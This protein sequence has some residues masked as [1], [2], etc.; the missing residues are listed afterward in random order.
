ML[1]KI[2]GT[3][4]AIGR[5]ISPVWNFIK[6]FFTRLCVFAKKHK[7]LSVIIAVLL[8]AA[9][10]FSLLPG[11][12]GKGEM[13]DTSEVTVSRMTISQTISGSSVVEANDEYSVTPLAYGEIL[14]ADF[15]EGDIVEKGQVLYEIDSSDA[16]S[17]IKSSDLS[18]ERAQNS[19]AD[20]ADAM[21]D[22][23]V[24]AEFSGTVTEVYVSEGDE[25]SNGAKIA[26]IVN[27]STMKVRVP[28]NTADAQ[29]IR[30]G[31]AATV[32]LVNTGKV[33]SGSITSVSSGSETLNGSMR[34]SYVT[35]KVSN[36]GA[37]MAGDSVTAMVGGYA[38]NDVGTFEAFESRTITAKV[39][40]TVSRLYVVKGDNVSSGATLA[41]LISESVDDQIRNADISLRE[42]QLQ[43]EKL[44]EQ[45]EDYTI[46]SPISGT[47][48]RKNKK[49]G[50]K[51]EGGASSDSNIL[52]VIYDMSSLCFQLD[53]DELDVKK[54]VVGQE[55]IITADA[56][57][58]RTYTGYVE[59][60]SINGTVGTNGVTTYPIKV[61]IQDFDDQLLPGMNI[62]AEIT[63]NKSENTLA[64][65]VTA[66][67]RGN[68]VY[69]KGD[70]QNEN[71]RAPEGFKTVQVEVGIS[72]DSF[73]EILSGVNEGDVVYVTPSTGNEQQ[74]MFPGMGGMPGG[75][76]PGG[77][78]PGGGMPGGSMQG[79]MQGG[80]RSGGMPGGGMR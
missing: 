13:P 5:F 24:K 33:L 62:E 37:V 53:V 61:R 29:N 72:D 35:I 16:L 75:G 31:E 55:V 30:I 40:G 38:C 70:K 34:V 73:V 41:K 1:N 7:I 14:S 23:T 46:T 8:V 44:Y 71:D 11:R 45:L 51:L 63:V 48:V 68:T 54:M 6:K 43:R 66:V 2:K 76:M 10:V 9:L 49:A 36:P 50:D 59:N 52:A 56:V 4:S 28:F 22:L 42:A 79:G 12:G 25:I 20:A 77:G 57:D 18:I 65:P 19:S 69:I 67:N 60:I 74:M 3:C 15:E 39:S 47:V 32:T 78:L 80:N 21:S 27:T 64:V 58:G 26:D 17:S